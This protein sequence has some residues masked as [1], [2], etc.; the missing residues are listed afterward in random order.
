MQYELLAPRRGKMS[1]TD[2]KVKIKESLN[3]GMKPFLVAATSGTTVLG[4]FDPLQE[5]ADVCDEYDL[6]LHVDVSHVLPPQ[7]CL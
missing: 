7:L 3:L 1:V 5:I 2:L 6:W 4:A